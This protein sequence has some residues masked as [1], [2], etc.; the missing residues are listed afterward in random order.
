MVIPA[1]GISAGL[2]GERIKTSVSDLLARAML[3]LFGI[4]LAAGVLLGVFGDLSH[5]S[6]VLE[7]TVA[8]ALLFLL[9]REPL[10]SVWC[11][12]MDRAEGWS[13]VKVG[14][15]LAGFCFFLNLIWVVCC[16]LEPTVD[17]YTNYNTACVI[18]ERNWREL[19]YL[20]LG[21][22]PHIFGYGYL[23]SFVLRLFGETPMVIAVLN[24]VLTTVSGI[25]IYAICLKKLP[26][27]AAAAAFFLWALCPSK[28]LYNTM[29]LPEPLYTCLLLLFFYLFLLAERA[30]KRKGTRA[31]LVMAL[32]GLAAGVVLF[33]VNMLRPLAAIAMIALGIWILLLRGEGLRHGRSWLCWSIFL[34]CLLLGFRPLS[35]YWNE[36]ETWRLRSELSNLP[37]YS[38]YVGLDMENGGSFSDDAM[39][40]LMDYRY[41][42]ENGTAKW[43]QEQMLND[44]VERLKSEGI[45]VPRLLRVKLPK[46]LGSDEGGS[47]YSAAALSGLAYALSSALSNVY[48]YMIVALV[49]LGACTLAK[50]SGSGTLILPLFSTGLILAHM[51]VEVA[52]RYKYCLIPLFVILSAYGL[53]AYKEK[54]R[55]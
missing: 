13:T 25:L 3:F 4:L 30:E 40:R 23:M 36:Y 45:S 18:A 42:E 54:E 38:I 7:F 34:A 51:I 24:V 41:D 28:L 5:L 17:Y 46:L 21:L 9:G 22:F 49:L 19:G 50:K 31:Y 43:A 47:Y 35:R 8:L 53:N 52:G 20:Y 16:R 32:I 44:A 12:L 14:A 37:A 15:C 55:V 48:Y 10:R 6:Y 39:N 11:D 33:G 27:G 2:E 1:A 26:R 29:V